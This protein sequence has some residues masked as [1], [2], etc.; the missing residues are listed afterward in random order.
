MRLSVWLLTLGLVSTSSAFSGEID[1]G[2]APE[3]E[4]ISEVRSE[5]EPKKEEKIVVYRSDEMTAL[6]SQIFE[7]GQ[8]YVEVEFDKNG[9]SERILFE[10][11]TFEGVRTL[12]GWSALKGSFIHIT[13]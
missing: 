7:L 5:Y 2:F 12:V 8:G 6:L 1:V 10:V 4:E 3:G 11:E 9:L 13:E